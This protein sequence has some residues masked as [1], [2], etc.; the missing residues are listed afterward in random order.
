MINGLPKIDFYTDI[1]L[2]QAF[3]LTFQA[4]KSGLWS[5]KVTPVK[6]MCGNIVPTAPTTWLRINNKAFA[7]RSRWSSTD[8]ARVDENSR[9]T[10]LEKVVL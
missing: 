6:K 2:V 8:K 5:P 4:L 3:F 1:S 10:F 9:S 7:A